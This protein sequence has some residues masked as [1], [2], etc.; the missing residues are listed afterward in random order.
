MKKTSMLIALIALAPLVM[1]LP[2][3]MDIYTPAIPAIT[4][5]FNVS[6]ATMQL[7]LN[8]FMLMS[9]LAQLIIG[10]LADRYGRRWTTFW[11]IILFS[12]GIG[13]CTF[14]HTIEMLIIGRLVEAIGSCGMLML[15]F[16]VGR[17][18]FTGKKL[19]QLYSL[20]NGI[21]SFSPMLAPFIG[22]YL[23][24]KWGW[25]STF[26]V[27]WIIAAL[28]LLCY[29]SLLGETLPAKKRTPINLTIFK[30]YAYILKNAVFNTYTL[31]SAIGMSY[32]FIF[33]A[34]SPVLLIQL[35]GV[36]VAHYGYYFCFMGISFFV[37]SLISAGVITRLGI[38]KTTALGYGLTLIGG[39]VMLVW[40]HIT[41]LTVNC[42]IIPM[43]LIG[44]GGTFCLSAGS[45]G[46][47]TP[48]DNHI[49]VASSLC[50]A[51]RFLFAALLGLA[52]ANS[53]TSV[54]PL[55]VPAVLLSL[56]GFAMILRY[57]AAMQTV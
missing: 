56:F 29:Y 16:T 26:A 44:M 21:I 53:I 12:I 18:L 15:G 49:G 30:D 5:L 40:Y 17:D 9:G 3:A 47:V 20:L 14:A 4:K 24:L 28:S 38:Y 11:L 52:I 42:F 10:P 37:G 51:F 36:P 25:A 45:A 48:F 23:D 6:T 1:A 33:C 13:L 19:G 32:L 55:A 22:S 34:T 31:S 7:T 27:L 2:I 8:L 35:L 46:A 43:L 39:I 57:K 41:G 54:L 50:T